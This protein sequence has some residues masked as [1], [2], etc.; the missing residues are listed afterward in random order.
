MNEKYYQTGDCKLAGTSFSEVYKTAWQVYSKEKRKS[1]RR[2]YIRSAYFQK[3]KIFIDIFW[4]HLKQKRLM[5]KK[6]RLKFYKCAIELL[7]NSKNPP[8]TLQDN[9]D[10]NKMLHR[11]FGQCK[12][13]EE[14]IVQIKENKKTGKK[15]L[16]SVFPSK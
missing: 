11:F 14:F 16:I 10:L 8:I 1:R 2:P 9:N 3:D 12:N 13:N 6:R 5:D 7:K 15:Y 4:S